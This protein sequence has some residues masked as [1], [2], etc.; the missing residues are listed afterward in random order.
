LGAGGGQENQQQHG[1]LEREDNAGMRKKGQAFVEQGEGADKRHA[2]HN[3]LRLVREHAEGR[4]LSGSWD[5]RKDNKK[6]KF[7]G[8]AKGRTWESFSAPGNGS[9][10]HPCSSRQPGGE[11]KKLK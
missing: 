5:G 4:N 3:S 6:T 1:E 10:L 2:L 8:T 11:M 7:F 9:G